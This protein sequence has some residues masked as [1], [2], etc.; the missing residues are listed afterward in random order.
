VARRLAL[1]I[2]LVLAAAGSVVVLPAAPAAAV[3]PPGAPTPPAHALVPVHPQRILDTR[4]DNQ[5]LGPGETRLLHVPFSSA[6]GPLGTQGYALNLTAVGPTQATHLSVAPYVVNGPPPT[7]SVMNLRA[8]ETRATMAITKTTRFGVDNRDW[9]IVRNN[10]GTVHLVIDVFGYV[11]PTAYANTDLAPTLP[12]RLVDTRA[13]L[14]APQAKLGPGQSLTVTATNA[15]TAQAALVNVTAVAPS[16]ATHLTAWRAGDPLPNTSSLNARPGEVTP[17]LVLTRLDAQKRFTVRN[18]SGSTDL[19]VDLVGLVTNNNSTRLG[20][21]APV[22]LLDTR[23]SSPLG[24][25]G[26][27]SALGTAAIGVPDDAVAVLVSVT[28]VS[29]SAPTH[30]TAWKYGTSMPTASTVNAAAGQTVA[31]ATIVPLGDLV[32]LMNVANNAG[33]AHVLIDVV[34]WLRY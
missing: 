34:G 8:G 17:N 12:T 7:T 27:R 2:A 33:T 3:L 19:V 14:G 10:S 22:R 5:P 4:T 9:F 11:G 13:G 32:K 24:P 1:A 6:L 20:L 23:T 31:N 30:L 16:A 25:G 29:P 15:P 28:I 26:T 21:I 18:N